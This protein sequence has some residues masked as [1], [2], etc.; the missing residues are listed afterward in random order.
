MPGLL[1]PRSG[2]AG[3]LLFHREEQQ[4]TDDVRYVDFQGLLEIWPSSKPTVHR[5]MKREVDPFPPG[6][7]IGG[8]RFWVVQVV[9]DWLAR[10][11]DATQRVK[12]A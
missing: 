7:M 1:R 11:N 12:A 6:Q 3:L 2:P 8:K 10:Q 5:A 9:L 4:M